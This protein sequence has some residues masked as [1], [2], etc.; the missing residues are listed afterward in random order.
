[1]VR[2][3]RAATVS[4]R[5]AKRATLLANS[6]RETTERSYQSAI[7]HYERLLGVSGPG[8]VPTVNRILD[9][10]VVVVVVLV[11][12]DN[13]APATLQK[14]ISAVKTTMEIRLGTI[15]SKEEMSLIERGVK[16]GQ[17][18]LARRARL[19]K[20]AGVLPDEAVEALTR[21]KPSPDSLDREIRDAALTA[22]CLVLRYYNIPY[23]MAKD[24][25]TSLEATELIATVS[26]G[27][28]KTSENE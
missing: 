14:Y 23:L 24:I 1:A 8:N 11:E 26:L 27:R 10:V 6:I 7:N 5:Q 25:N 18:R 19:P 28:T 12:Q 2:E 13:I 17:A 15:F 16:G 9:L 3:F 4:E 20:S 21:M 22:T